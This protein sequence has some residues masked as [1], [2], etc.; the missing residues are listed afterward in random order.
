MPERNRE[1]RKA[2][3]GEGRTGA[4]WARAPRGSVNIENEARA[5]EPR[6]PSASRCALPR[7][8]GALC[9]AGETP[10][11]RRGSTSAAGLSPGLFLPRFPTLVPFC[12]VSSEH[13]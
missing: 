3:P 1:T 11:R 2:R 13:S 4:G 12:P 6:E 5:A 8:T 7:A 9:T 10:S